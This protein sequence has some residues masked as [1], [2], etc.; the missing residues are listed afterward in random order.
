[1]NRLRRPGREAVL[2]VLF[3]VLAIAGVAFLAF[4]GGDD[5]GGSSGPTAPA[6]VT[7]DLVIRDE[8]LS[9]GAYNA[10]TGAFLMRSGAVATAWAH[11]SGPAAPRCTRPN[12]PARCDDRGFRG[13]P[14]QFDVR[15]SKDQGRTWLAPFPDETVVDA[16]PYAYTG[17]PVIALKAAPG[18]PD[19][20]LL[21]RVNGEDI[22]QFPE[23][24]GVPG[25]AFLQRRAPGAAGWTGRQILLDPARFTYNISRIHRLRDGKTLIALGGFW[26]V[27]AGQR[28]TSHS[29]A[30][31]QWLLMESTDEGQTWHNALEVPTSASA[32]A[33]ANEWDV[34]ELSGGDLLAVMRTR[35]GD[36]A[37]RK[38]V[39]LSK[40]DDTITT[41]TAT[42]SDGGWKMGTPQ[43]TPPSFPQIDGPQHPDLV[44]IE[45][46]PARGGIL[47]IADEGIEYTG[48]GGITWA[49][50]TFSRGWTPHYYP[51]AV[52]APGGNIYIFSQAGAD[53]DYTTNLN[54]PVYL[55]VIRLVPDRELTP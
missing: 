8:V 20:T 23:F 1:M 33:P 32:V 36:R 53:D 7:G 49:K 45:Y 42:R 34:A 16:Q 21:R 5:S 18:Q 30:K 15:Q 12:V 6:A 25:T 9:S 19:G 35:D 50:L 14:E 43:L 28:L 3:G 39:I 46:G 10:F 27:P 22:S 54:K 52:Q 38:Q 44:S 13:A 24:S 41:N 29:G 31:G 4:G 51:N 47:H 17:Q 2:A 37:V 55:D 40:T 26:E 11:V 48:D